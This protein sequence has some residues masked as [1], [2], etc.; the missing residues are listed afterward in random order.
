M[1]GVVNFD[2]IKWILKLRFPLHFGMLLKLA[3][4]SKVHISNSTVCSHNVIKVHVMCHL[5]VNKL[6]CCNSTGIICIFMFYLGIGWWYNNMIKI[7]SGKSFTLKCFNFFELFLT[8]C[9]FYRA[10]TVPVNSS[11]GRLTLAF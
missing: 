2:H 5:M 11:S 9:A 3:F 8:F 7:L 10:F 6:L 4:L 1:I